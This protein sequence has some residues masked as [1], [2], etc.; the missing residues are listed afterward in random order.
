MHNKALTAAGLP[1]SAFTACAAPLARWRN[2]WNA[3]L[4]SRRR[5]WATS[6]ARPPR[7]I[8]A[9]A[10]STC[11]ACGTPRLRLDSERSLFL[12]T[13]IRLSF[14]PAGPKRGAP[15][16]DN[17][18]ITV[19]L[20]FKSF[21]GGGEISARDAQLK[22]ARSLCIGGKDPCDQAR[23]IRRI[24]NAPET[25]ALVGSQKV[26]SIVGEDADDRPVRYAVLTSPAYEWDP[27]EPIIGW[28][29]SEGSRSSRYGKL[30]T[31]RGQ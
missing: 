7:S 23:S 29:W 18:R 22:A 19:Y 1:A 28:I 11:C 12:G 2:G 26:L 17:R 5:S 13:Y 4:E 27:L 30:T 21:L 20:A 25:L 8:T 10:R 24:L 16:N 15:R 9:C 14:G 6:Q 3:P 31:I